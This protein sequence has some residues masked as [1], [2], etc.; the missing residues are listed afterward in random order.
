[1]NKLKF[2]MLAGAFIV[3]TA[4]TLSACGPE[5]PPELKK[6]AAVIQYMMAPPNLSRSAFCVAF[7]EGKPSQYVSYLF[8]TMGS[9]EW[10]PGEDWVDK[11][12]IE[13]ARVIGIPISPRGVTFI[14]RNRKNSAGSQLVIGCDDARGV[15]ILEGYGPADTE[16]ALYRE[17]TLR[18]VNP[19]PGVALLFE[20]NAQMGMDAQSFD[21]AV[22]GD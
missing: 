10:P 3:L 18:E 5:E 11:I 7:P 19:A 6:A 15:V 20:S 16:P 2:Q 8:S 21:P 14:P 22:R 17:I 4:L 1:M 12:E 9:A 13:T